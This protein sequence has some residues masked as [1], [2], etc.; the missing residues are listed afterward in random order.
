MGYKT[1]L[2]KMWL[3]AMAM[4][5]RNILDLL[6]HNPQHKVLDLGCDDGSWTIEIAKSIGSDKLYGIDIVDQRL[7]KAKKRGIIVKKADINKKWPFKDNTFDCIHSNQ[8]IEHI[9][10]LDQFAGETKRVLKK[11]GYAIISTENLA[12]WVNIGS[13]LFGW[14]PFS[15]TNISKERLGIGNPIAI[16]RNEE[17][18][19][20]SWLHTRV[21]TI[22]AI[23]EIFEEHGMIT[24]RV[25]GSGYF[26]LPSLIGK[27][28]VVHSHFI[29][30]LIRNG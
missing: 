21:L 16:H 20:S 30:F 26:P 15:L 4:N 12:S 5:K 14:Q 24:E 1:T 25:I 17:L 7:N 8:V 22:K 3:S 2:S 29:T 28:E 13:L 11:G 23:R 6:E 18:K 9:W 10:D 19:L 27:Y